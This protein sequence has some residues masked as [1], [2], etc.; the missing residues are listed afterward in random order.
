MDAAL[1]SS[2]RQDWETPDWLLDDVR[3]VFGREIACDP[4]TTAANPTRARVFHTPDDPP[5]GCWAGPWF[6]N[7]PYGRALATQW[8]P[9][10]ARQQWE[11]I[12]LLP[13]RTDTAWFASVWA[14]SG[15]V[16][17]LRGR[18]TFKGAP[19][20]APFPSAVFYRGEAPRVFAE[21]FGE[22][23]RVV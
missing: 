22:R 8:A 11:G 6:C 10:I 12:A 4:C 2:D 17:F 13:A 16:C 9:M 15:L 14:S 21:V 1:L 23:G 18:L 5:P 20:P 7:P 19:H 3:R